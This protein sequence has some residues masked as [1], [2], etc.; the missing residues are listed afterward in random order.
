MKTNAKSHNKN[1]KKISVSEMNEND[2]PYIREIKDLNELNAQGC[3]YI[4]S[5]N[6]KNYTRIITRS[7]RWLTVR[8]GDHFMSPEQ[9]KACRRI[10][11]L[12]FEKTN[13]IDRN[14]NL[15]ILLDKDP[16]CLTGELYDASYIKKLIL[17]GADVRFEDRDSKMKL[18]LQENELYLSFSS[19]YTK[20]VNIGYHYIGKSKE[21]GLCRFIADEF[22]ARFMKAQRLAVVNDKIVLADPT[23]TEKVKTAF[24]L[25]SREW[26]IIFLSIVASFGMGILVSVLFG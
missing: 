22:D 17:I 23:I 25:T 4:L 15:H 26:A 19:D 21:D 20:M 6:H 3:R 13:Q 12:T 24:N 11:A 9:E 2:S 14:L 10:N 16:R 5:A 8:Q 7:M 18:V 1:Q